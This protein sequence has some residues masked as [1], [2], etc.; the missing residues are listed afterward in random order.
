M[1][2][3]NTAGNTEITTLNVEQKLDY[4]PVGSPWQASQFFNIV[5]GKESGTENANLLKTGARIDYSLTKRLSIFAGGSF[6]RNKFA[7][8]SRR[9][10]SRSA[11]PS[12]R[13]RRRSR[14]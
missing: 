4:Q 3:V 2:F 10:R 12:R 11:W 8:I 9:F 6:E 13:S 14:I 5:Y 7:G 1:G